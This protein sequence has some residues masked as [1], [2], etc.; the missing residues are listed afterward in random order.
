MI[1]YEGIRGPFKG[2]GV[3]L[4]TTSFKIGIH[5]QFYDSIRNYYLQGGEYNYT[6]S[7]RF[8]RRFAVTM[9]CALLTYS[10]VY[11]FELVR[12]HIY[13]DSLSQTIS[14]HT[15]QKTVPTIKSL[16]ALYGRRL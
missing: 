7:D 4:L 2:S 13:I 3:Q 11:P 6:G 16:K 10:L 14:K 1:K 8:V 9:T 5:S 15:F 12:T